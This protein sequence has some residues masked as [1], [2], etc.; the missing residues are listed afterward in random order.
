MIDFNRLRK[1]VG[2]RNE[3]IA[4][5]VSNVMY[6]NITDGEWKIILEMKGSMFA[7][8]LQKI[9]DE[10]YNYYVGKLISELQAAT[11]HNRQVDASIYGGILEGLYES[12]YR[13]LYQEGLKRQRN[14]QEKDSRNQKKL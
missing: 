6:K 8:I 3:E 2:K 11:Q 10:Q 5:I 9:Q 13:T 12:N 4:K 14:R 7:N 1:E